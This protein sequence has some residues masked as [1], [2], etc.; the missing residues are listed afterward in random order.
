M[1]YGVLA[2]IPAVEEAKRESTPRVILFSGHRIDVEGREKPRFPRDKE[3]E[4]RA[5]ILE[6]VQE[7]KEKA[8]GRP[9][10][11]IAGCAS[12]GDILFHE[13]CQELGITTEVYL[14][15]PK[16][17]YVRASVTDGGDDWAERFWLICGRCKVHVMTDSPRLPPWLRT[18]KDYGIWQRSNL[19]M[20]YAALARSGSDLTLIA[21]WD[22][23][24]GDGPG[25][26]DDMVRIVEE[27]GAVSIHI[28][29]RQLIEGT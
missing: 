15:L 11:G 26:T 20:L 24:P 13:T 16:R 18:K 3:A 7:R 14:A 9:L 17:A 12:G 28:D 27:R 21:L 29:A 2:A 1:S 5:L 10:L 23:K 25:G 22:G 4:A 8:K 6:E 19:W